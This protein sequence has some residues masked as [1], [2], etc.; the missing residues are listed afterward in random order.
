MA[1]RRSFQQSPDRSQFGANGDQSVKLNIKKIEDSIANASSN[2]REYK[3]EIECL[4]QDIAMMDNHLQTL[5]DENIKV[6][7]PL[8]VSN[9]DHLTSQIQMQKNEND[10]MQKQLTELKKEKSLMQQQIMQASQKIA[11]LEDSVGL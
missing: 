5:N 6:I 1:Q 11:L 9:F 4:R 8:V 2:L 10:H 3:K 7:N